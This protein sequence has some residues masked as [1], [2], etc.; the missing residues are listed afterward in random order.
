[1]VSKK[2]TDPL[3]RGTI[4]PDD[5]SSGFAAWSGTSFA[6]PVLAGEVAKGLLALEAQDP[7]VLASTELAVVTQRAD[8]AVT[9][10][11]GLEDT[12]AGKDLSDGD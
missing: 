12:P 8:K 11:S 2:R 6:A 5:Y 3:P 1:M 7:G 10:A 4:D 9:W